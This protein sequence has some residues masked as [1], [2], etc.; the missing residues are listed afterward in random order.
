APPMRTLLQKAQNLLPRAVDTK[1][2]GTPARPAPTVR[3]DIF[4]ASASGAKARSI[5]QLHSQLPPVSFVPTAK[6]ALVQSLAQQAPEQ[7]TAALLQQLREATGSTRRERLG[8]QL[9]ETA[10]QRRLAYLEEA[11]GS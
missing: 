3:P 7:R 1:G 9:R 8:E 5:A 11:L 4:Q 2:S 10:P 6:L